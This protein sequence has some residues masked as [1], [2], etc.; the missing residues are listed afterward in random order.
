MSLYNPW[1]SIG[2]RNPGHWDISSD[3]GRWFRI[4]GTPGDV[5]VYDERQDESR[6]HPRGTIQFKS[7]A[8]AMAWAIDE[9]M[10]SIE[11]KE[12]KQP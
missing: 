9:I 2:Y 6:P 7:V 8:T 11:A 4:R 1:F 12:G 5:H 10:G 3:G